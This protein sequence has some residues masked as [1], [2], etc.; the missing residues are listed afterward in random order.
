M[1]IY[2]HV[3]MF[4]YIYIYILLY[5]FGDQNRSEQI[6]IKNEVKVQELM[7]VPNMHQEGKFSVSSK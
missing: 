4:L 5:H 7:L 6:S 2:V 3:Y 1:Y